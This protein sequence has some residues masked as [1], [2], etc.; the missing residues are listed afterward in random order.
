MVPH[1]ISE[2]RPSPELTV[3]TSGHKEA[4]VVII[5]FTL[6]QSEEMIPV[7]YIY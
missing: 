2:Q 5:T 1:S 4:S 3:M 6:V 7:S